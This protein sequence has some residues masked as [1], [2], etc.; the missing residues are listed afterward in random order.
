MTAKA[1]LD[2][3]VGPHASPAHGNRKMHAK[4]GPNFRPSRADREMRADQWLI[5]V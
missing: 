1:P 2:I 5:F 3:E 4:G